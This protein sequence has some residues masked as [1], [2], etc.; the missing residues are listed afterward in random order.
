LAPHFVFDAQRLSKFDGERFVC[1]IDKPWTT[2]A[3]WNV[4]VCFKSC[5]IVVLN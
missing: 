1:F 5:F 3:F 2:D 4:Q